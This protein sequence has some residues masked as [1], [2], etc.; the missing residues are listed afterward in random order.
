MFSG[1]TLFYQLLITICLLLAL[2]AVTRLATSIYGDVDP[3]KSWFAASPDLRWDR[4]RN[5]DGSDDCG[6]HRAFDNWGFRIADSAQVK[7]RTPNRHRVI[8]LGDEN[9]FG[10]CV[11]TEATFVEV[12]DRLL[13][14]HDLI[15]LGVPGYT[16]YQGYKEL[17]KYGESIKPEIIFISFNFNDRRYVINDDE[18]DSDTAFRRLAEKSRAQLLEHSYLFRAVRAL[19]KKAGIIKS[20]AEASVL[21]AD[22][23][24]PRVDPQ[25][26]SA[27]LIKMVQWARQHGATPYFILLGDNPYRTALL[28]KGISKLEQN[29]NDGAINDFTQVVSYSQSVVGPLARKYL[30]SAYSRT[31]QKDQAQQALLFKPTYS[32]YGGQPIFQDIVYNQIMRDVAREYNVKL[33]DAEGKLDETPRVYSDCCHFGAEGHEIVGKM[34]SEFLDRNRRQANKEAI[35]R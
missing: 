11:A 16:S 20:P 32:L 34:I 14:N 27:N 28:R 29:D 9:T 15:N 6:A 35:V 23:L 10:Y 7:T 22:K 18:V 1:K 4:A 33:V 19:G 13:P 12:A 21:R 17:L 25:S 8:F 3:D 26:Y 2:E 24:K 30:A 5:F 31:G